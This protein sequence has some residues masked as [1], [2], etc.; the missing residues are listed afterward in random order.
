MIRLVC[1]FHFLPE[2]IF[3]RHRARQRRDAF[4]N[5]YNILFTAVGCQLWSVR[6]KCEYRRSFL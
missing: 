3:A 1:E 4:Q 5:A 6:E 2:V